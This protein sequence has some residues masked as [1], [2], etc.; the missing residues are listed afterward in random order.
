[1]N[2][3]DSIVVGGGCFW[4]LDAL[5]RRVNGVEVVTSGYAGGEKQN[6]TY[7][8]LHSPNNT[9]AEVVKVDFDTTQIDLDTI[10]QIFWAMHDPTTLNQ[11]GYDVGVEYR[12]IILYNSAE[13]LKVVEQSIEKTAKKLWSKPITTEVKQLETFWEAEE[14]QQNWFEKH[15]EAGYCQIIINPKVAKLKQK[16]AHLIR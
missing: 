1:M 13:Q 8:D 4:C 10:L 3:Q 14:E 5:Y 11:Q 16:F 2:S 9:H 6:P 15:P 12:S 7:W